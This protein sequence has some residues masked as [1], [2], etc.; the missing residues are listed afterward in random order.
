MRAL[1]RFVMKKL[2]I[3][4]LKSRRR[5]LKIAARKGIIPAVIVYSIHKNAPPVFAREPI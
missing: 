4:N 1:I 2:R 3:E 5:F